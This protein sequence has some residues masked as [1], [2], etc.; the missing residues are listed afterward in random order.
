MDLKNHPG[1]FLNDDAAASLERLENDHGVQPITDAGR[2]K[3]K[4]Q[5]LI[6]RWNAGGKYNRPPYLYEPARPAETSSH[7]KNGGEA[8]DTSAW[9]K[10]LEFAEEYG[11]VQDFDWDVVHFRYDKSKDKHLPAPA[12]EQEEETEMTPEQW[13]Y[14]QVMN[15]KLDDIASGIA[16]L[17]VAIK[18]PEQLTPGMNNKLDDLV[19]AAEKLLARE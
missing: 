17:A 4:Q 1:M 18:Q 8:V 10:W 3:Q 13:E 5:S 12:G 19:G 15:T 2:T 14:L 6:D 9:R 16:V 11:Y 7:V